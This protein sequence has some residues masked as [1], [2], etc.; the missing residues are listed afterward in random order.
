VILSIDTQNPTAAAR[1]TLD[2]YLRQQPKDPAALTRLAELRQH[3]GATGQAIEAYQKAI[4]ADSS[5]AP[6]V[7]ELAILYSQRPAD[8][9]KAFDL[10]TKARQASPNDA[11]VAK[12]LGILNVQR[13][14]YLQSL[15]LLNQAATT[16]KDDSEVQYY[17][18][19]ANQG[20]KRWDGCKA[21]L[22][23]AIA[24]HLSPKLA[25]DAQTRLANCT[26]MSA[27]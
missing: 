24:L 3:D 20:L 14:V 21:A 19:R 8:E 6:A 18:G 16:R 11:E 9:S 1:A 2:D 12:T 26:E 17:L 4:D 10:A 27:P 15:E 5:Y 7:R 25:D 23:K 13:G 22:E